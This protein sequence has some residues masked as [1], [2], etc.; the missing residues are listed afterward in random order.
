MRVQG[1]ARYAPEALPNRLCLMGGTH[2]P[3][4]A[5]TAMITPMLTTDFHTAAPF[6]GSAWPVLEPPDA[7]PPPLSWPPPPLLWPSP[8]AACEPEDEPPVPPLPPPLEWPSADGGA[9]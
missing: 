8:A 7:C 9:V 5:A 4:T 1:A 2:A 3:K 6:F